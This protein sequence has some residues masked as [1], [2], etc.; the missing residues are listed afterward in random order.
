MVSIDTG[1]T[2]TFVGTSQEVAQGLDVKL[3]VLF[4]PPETTDFAPVAAQIADR[5]PR[6]LGLILTTQMVPFFNAL[7]DEGIS[8]RDI[9]I[10]TAVILMAPEVL[11]QLGDKAD[12]MYLLTQQRPR[13]TRTTPASS[14]CSRSS[15]TRASTRTATR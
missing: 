6:R 5:N 15:R 4:I 8:P 1:L 2:R 7:D 9:P 10:F 12:G 11:E 14:R 3:D 13:R